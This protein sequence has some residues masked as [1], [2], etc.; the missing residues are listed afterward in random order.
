MIYLLWGGLVLLL[1]Y[2]VLT[3][4]NEQPG[5]TI[6][7]LVWAASLRSRLLPFGFGLLMG[8]FFW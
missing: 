8:H 1:V 2:E 7:E 3:L 4:V 6:S 5:D